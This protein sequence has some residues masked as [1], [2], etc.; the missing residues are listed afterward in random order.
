MGCCESK[1]SEF[2]PEYFGSSLKSCINT[3]NTKLLSY[4]I[5]SYNKQQKSDFNINSSFLEEGIGETNLL[6]YSLIQ[7]RLDMFKH[8]HKSLNADLNTMENIF[9]VQGLN[10]LSIICENNFLELFEYYAPLYFIMKKTQ[11]TLRNKLKET[12]EFDDKYDKLISAIDN[13]KDCTYTPIQRACLH[14]HIGMVGSAIEL[15]KK[16]DKVPI[17]LDVNYVDETTGDNCALIACKTGNY[18]MI[19]FLHSN[20]NTD[21]LLLNKNRENALQVLAASA[22]LKHLSEFL[23]C[24]IYIVDK[25]KLDFTY[26]YQETIL[27]LDYE[28]VLTFFVSKLSSAGISANKSELETQANRKTEKNARPENEENIEKFT[29]IKLFPELEVSSNI[30]FVSLASSHDTSVTSIIF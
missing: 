28:K 30:S 11:K 26:N 24:F 15:S 29:L 23:Q 19:K 4:C 3:G 21:F 17:E 2:S 20:H 18:S 12:I 16:M 6:G 9:E 5:L 1:N 27:L 22:R 14:G 10:G 8:I 7:G 25:I 13:P